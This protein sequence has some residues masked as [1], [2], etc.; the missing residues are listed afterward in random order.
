MR[1]FD[2]LYKTESKRS[3]R[4]AYVIRWILLAFLFA[5]AIVQFLIPEQT[6]AG[7]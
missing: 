3:E 7:R 2:S 1:I 5:M 4:T 6:I